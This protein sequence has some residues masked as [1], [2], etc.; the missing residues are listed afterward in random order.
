MMYR[1][2]IIGL[3]FFIADG[4]LHA[5]SIIQSATQGGNILLD[6][7]QDK[8]NLASSVVTDSSADI[9]GGVLSIDISTKDK[10]LTVNNLYSFQLDT[11]SNFLVFG[12][13]ASGK[14]NNSISS[15]FNSG[16]VVG[17]SEASLIFGYKLFSI[18]NRSE[19]E[20]FAEENLLDTDYTK[21]EL[22]ERIGEI[23]QMSGHWIY[24][25]PMIEGRKFKS[26]NQDSSFSNQLVTNRNSL[27]SLKLG[28]NYWSPNILG[29]Q[30]LIGV[31]GSKFFE[32]NFDDLKEVTVSDQMIF[33]SGNVQRNALSKETAY[34]GVYQASD[35]Y[36]LNFEGYF[37]PNK[38]PFFGLYLA[39]QTTMEDGKKPLSQ[40]VTGIFFSDY[41][42]VLNPRVGLVMSFNDIYDD[43]GLDD[44]KKFSVN[45]VTRFNLSR[46]FK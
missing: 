8:V 44:N 35:K 40:L 43:R 16:D 14:I 4:D 24:F 17:G 7:S 38:L 3:I 41:A 11:T 33:T 39:H 19:I 1:L 30:S 29:F 37:S 21:E 2:V 42:E 46:A 15:L 31:S 22:K 32:D 9:D 36:G 26:F 20:K 6:G 25:M 12:I 28:Y 18:K 27:W 45:L 5:Q 23:G 13:T 10:K 34:T